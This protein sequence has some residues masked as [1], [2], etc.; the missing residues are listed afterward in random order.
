VPFLIYGFSTSV[1]SLIRKSSLGKKTKFG[2]DA[3][4]TLLKVPSSCNYHDLRYCP[5]RWIRPKV[6]SFD[7]P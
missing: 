3:K 2:F 4:T 1:K 5:A 6:G 7:R